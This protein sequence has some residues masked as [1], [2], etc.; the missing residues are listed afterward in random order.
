MVKVLHVSNKFFY[1]ATFAQIKWQFK[2][3][4]YFENIINYSR[5]LEILQ[6]KGCKFEKI[7]FI[8]NFWQFC[9]KNDKEHKANNTRTI[10]L[11]NLT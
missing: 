6:P 7:T 4:F 8:K 9:G 3:N 1:N 11:F 10:W 5:I 2:N